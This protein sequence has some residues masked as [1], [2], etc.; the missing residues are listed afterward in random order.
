MDERNLRNILLVFV[1]RF[2]RTRSNLM[3]ANMILQAIS[4]MTPDQRA[5]LT[6]AQIQAQL[7]DCQ[8]QLE[9]QPDPAGVEIEKVLA[10]EG[11][12]ENALGKF[13]AGLQW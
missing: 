5:K 11:P 12:F 13:V 10:N 2:N 4:S 3:A 9:T 6:S 8:K 1:K 7:K